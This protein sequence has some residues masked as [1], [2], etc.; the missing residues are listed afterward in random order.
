MK[1]AYCLLLCVLLCGCGGEEATIDASV[2]DTATIPVQ[3]APAPAPE[4]IEEVSPYVVSNGFFLGMKPGGSIAEFK[5][6]LRADVLQTGEGD[7]D[8][9]Y[10]DGAEGNELGYLMPDPRDEKMIGSIYITAEEVITEDGI[11]VGMRFAELQ[12]K[13]GEVAVH[14]SEIEGMTYASK[15]G[16]AYRLDT[17]IWTYE[18]DLSEIKPATKLLEIVIER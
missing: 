14:G 2:T 15:N 5:D 4:E 16:L 13:I 8:V 17:N 9:F 3:E 7:F 1:P 12:E 10:I 18:V 11:S 6:G